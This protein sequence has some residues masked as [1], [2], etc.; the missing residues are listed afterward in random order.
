MKKT[1]IVEIEYEELPENLEQNADV[2][3]AVG[4]ECTLEDMM[5]DYE[6]HKSIIGEYEVTVKQV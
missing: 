5:F 2:I 1:F 4:L 6:Q 3:T